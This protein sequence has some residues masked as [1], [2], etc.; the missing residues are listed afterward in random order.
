MKSKDF[1]PRFEYHK[2][3]LY[4]IIGNRVSILVEKITYK[5]A[6]IRTVSIVLTVVKI[7]V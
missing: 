6:L 3:R 4:L 2:I 7:F 1:K 5:L